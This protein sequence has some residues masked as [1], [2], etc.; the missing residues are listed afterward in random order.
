MAAV[1][2]CSDFGTP[3]NKVRHCFPITSWEIDGETVE[4][5]GETVEIVADFI[6]LGSKITADGDCN[7]DR[8]QP[9]PQTSPAWVLQQPMELSCLEPE[10]CLS[11]KRAVMCPFSS[12]ISERL[13][14]PGLS[15]QISI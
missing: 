12:I 14:A 3:K 7:H 8:K 4:I 11:F 5:D 10:P 13:S 15:S 6:F 1:I 9:L 2:I